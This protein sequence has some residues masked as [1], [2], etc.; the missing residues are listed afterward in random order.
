R[1]STFR[2]APVM[3]E[4]VGRL[5]NVEIITDAVVRAARPGADGRL[6][7]VEIEES[8]T[9]RAISAHGL[10]VAIGHD[11]RSAIGGGVLSRSATD[12][13]H[14]TGPGGATD[15]PGVFVAGDVCDDRFRQA[16]T[17]AGAGCAAALEASRYLEGIHA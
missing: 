5:T 1:S 3:L 7:T 6:A 15:L 9:P 14:T 17:A 4:R 2:A 11:P 10:F 13:I 8:G 12:H 16:V